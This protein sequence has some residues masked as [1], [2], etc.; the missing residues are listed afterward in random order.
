MNWKKILKIIGWIALGVVALILAYHLILLLISLV[1]TVVTWI[2]AAVKF[3]LIGFVALL[4]WR[5]MPSNQGS[6]SGRHHSGFMS[7]AR[8]NIPSAKNQVPH[9]EDQVGSAM[10]N[11]SHIFRSDRDRRRG[12]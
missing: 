6:S 1:V 10:D 12:R 9:A 7:D 5:L 11:V 8:D 2:I 4:I 3:V